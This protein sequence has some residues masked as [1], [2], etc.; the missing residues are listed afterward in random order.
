MIGADGEKGSIWMFVG[1]QTG[2]V[3]CV[4]KSLGIEEVLR[5]VVLVVIRWCKKA[6]PVKRSIDCSD[7]VKD[8]SWFR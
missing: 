5:R 1:E 4:Y 8:Y 3:G 7:F 2:C 6:V